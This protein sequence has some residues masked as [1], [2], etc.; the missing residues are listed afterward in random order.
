MPDDV[1]PQAAAAPAA[2]PAQQAVHVPQQASLPLEAS[3]APPAVAEVTAPALDLSQELDTIKKRYADSS[4]EALRLYRENEALKATRTSTPDVHDPFKGYSKANWEALK[5]MRLG[6]ALEA[7]ASGNTNAAKE[8]AHQVALIDARLREV[9]LEQH[10]TKQ[11]A[12]TAFEQLKT[13]ALPILNKFQGEF[14]PGAPLL[15]ETNILYSQAIQ[16]GMPEGDM[17][18]AVAVLLAL[19]KNGKFE[20]GVA[21]QASQAATKNLNQAIK[22]AAAAGSGAANINAAPAPD[23]TKM[24]SD[25]FREYRKSIGVGT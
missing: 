21:A 20:Q 22:S 9:E 18:K 8:S 1:T 16:A 5:E 2:Q 7:A 24:N 14:Q 19:A 10:A 12:S 23:F 11:T 17:T 6:E 13:V 3:T 25:Q 15:Q 4:A